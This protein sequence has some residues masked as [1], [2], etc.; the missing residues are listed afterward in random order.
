MKKATKIGP[1]DVV[2]LN[3]G[4]PRMVVVRLAAPGVT[5][6]CWWSTEKDVH[7]VVAPLAALMKVRR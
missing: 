6:E 4:G 7:T 3:S 5:V 2:R 1:G